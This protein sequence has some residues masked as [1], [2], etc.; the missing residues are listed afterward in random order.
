MARL[1]A[2]PSRLGGLPPRVARGTD[3]E[4]HSPQ[5]EPWRAW[6]SSPEWR[7]LRLQV[8]L[9]DGYTC[10]ADDCGKVTGRPIA[11]HKR[12]HRGDPALFFDPT[13]VQTLCKPCHDGWK[14]RLEARARG[15]GG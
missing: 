12:R 7:A 8:F 14:Q 9:R 5:L 10:Q 13:N 3:A 11:D 6:Y 4:G 2:M 1:S 15:Q